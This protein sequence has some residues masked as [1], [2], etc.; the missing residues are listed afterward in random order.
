MS[1][2]R[3][4]HRLLAAAAVAVCAGSVFTSS[5]TASAQITTLDKGHSLL[6]SSGLQ[7]WGLNTDSFQYTFNYNNFT[8]ANMNAVMWSYG[9]SNPGALS[10]GQKWGK[11]VMPDPANP[12]YTSPANSL[13]STENAH[14]NDLVALQI[15]DEQQSDLENTSGY[16]KAWFDAAHNAGLFTDKLMYI[17]STF[18]NDASK[19]INFIGA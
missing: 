14:K 2:S 15:G 13:N 4:R 1:L 11:W 12:S 18:W 7:I 9:Q 3:S 10:N 19:F 5:Q 6:L 8:A 17:N 16:T